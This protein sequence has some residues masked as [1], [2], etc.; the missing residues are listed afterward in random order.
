MT[1]EDLFSKL[2]HF[3]E[4]THPADGL[5]EGLQ[6]TPKRVAKAYARWFGGYAVDPSSLLKTFGDGAEGYDQLVH[7]QNIP[8]WSHCEHHMAPFFG[9]A[10]VAYIP[11]RRV[12][13]LSKLFRVVDA[14]SRR[15]QVQERI[16]TQVA[17]CINDTLEPKGV[18]VVLECRHT[19]MESRGIERSNVATTTAALR[20]VFLTQPDTRAEFYSL[21][22]R[23]R[24][25]GTL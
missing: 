9:V 10:H 20:G 5:R 11:D 25:S 18:A 17:D 24:P 22:N 6:E 4:K 21:V 7:Q 2:L 12:V 13:G 3:V 23:A 1:E 8:V 14:F 19:C 15:L 16:T